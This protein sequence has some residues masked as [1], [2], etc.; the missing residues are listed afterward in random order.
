MS[1]CS[2]SGRS[3]CFT[4]SITSAEPTRSCGF[5]NAVEFPGARWPGY[6]GSKS[7]VGSGVLAIANV[8]LELRSGRLKADPRG[9]V[10]RTLDATRRLQSVTQSQLTVLELVHWLKPA[11]VLTTSADAYDRLTSRPTLGPVTILYCLQ[12]GGHRLLRDAELDGRAVFRAVVR[13]LATH[14]GSI[15][16]VSRGDLQRCPP[17]A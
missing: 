15:A 1:A 12:L 5:P 4:T 7:R 14:G 17:G 9:E 13:T 11:V 16:G 3:T 8:H 10:A 6:L 2:Q